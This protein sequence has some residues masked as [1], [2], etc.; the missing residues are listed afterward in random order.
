MSVLY[1]L[2]FVVVSRVVVLDKVTDFILFLGQL[3]ITAG[4]GKC[5]ISV[6]IS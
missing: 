1:V 5:Y 3:S 6:M 2:L 4:I